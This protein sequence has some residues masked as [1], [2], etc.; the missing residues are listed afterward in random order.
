MNRVLVTARLHLVHPLVILGN[1]WL[2]AL[3]SFALSWA[4]RAIAGLGSGPGFDGASC[5]STSRC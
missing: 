4:I 3:S 1:P 5:R 2:I